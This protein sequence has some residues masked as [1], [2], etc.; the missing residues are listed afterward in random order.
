MDKA[1][2]TSM[3]DTSCQNMPKSV[4]ACTDDSPSTPL[5]ARNDEYSTMIKLMSIKNSPVKKECPEFLNTI[6]TCSP[7]TSVSHGKTDAFST[8]SH[9]QKPPKFNDSY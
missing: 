3:Y 7:A 5:R 9:A 1:R 2:K 8:G 4:K 6:S